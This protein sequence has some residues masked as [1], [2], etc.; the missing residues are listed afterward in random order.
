MRNV[1]GRIYLSIYIQDFLVCK[2]VRKR[3]KQGKLELKNNLRL[4][5]NELKLKFGDS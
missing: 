3:I 1:I 4:I 5:R 2:S